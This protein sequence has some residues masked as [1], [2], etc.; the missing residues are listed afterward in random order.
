MTSGALIV[1]PYLVIV[2]GYLGVRIP[3]ASYLTARYVRVSVSVLED[4]EICTISGYTAV[5]I[6]SCILI[7]QMWA[8]VEQKVG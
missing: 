1:L 4:Q 5:H 6:R 7:D 2:L 8:N 3:F